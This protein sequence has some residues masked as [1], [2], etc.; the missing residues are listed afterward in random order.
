MKPKLLNKMIKHFSKAVDNQMIY[1]KKLQDGKTSL[2]KALQ[3]LK[4]ELVKEQ[5]TI[6][7]N[8]DLR[9]FFAMYYQVNMARQEAFCLQINKQQEM[10]DVAQDVLVSIKKEQMKFEKLLENYN[11]KISEEENKQETKELDEFS[12]IGRRLQNVE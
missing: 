1:I 4:D 7:Y 11:L 6:S 9:Q 3:N 10:I 2:E 8:I 12:I 5:E